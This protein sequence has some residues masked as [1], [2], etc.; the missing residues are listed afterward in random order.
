MLAGLEAAATRHETPCGAGRMVWRV[1]NA[2]GGAP[3]LLLHG[4]SGSWRHWVKQIPWLAAQ[5]M[6]IA[7][8]LPGL[9][10][11]DDPP[12]PQDPATIAGVLVEGLSGIVADTAAMDLVGFSFGAITAGH[13]ARL[14]APRLRSVT[15]CGAGALG[16]PRSPTSLVKVRD[17]QGAERVAAHRHNLAALMFAD[18][19]R[20][21]P[22]ALAIQEI[23]SQAA[24][25]KSRQFAPSANLKDA[26]AAAQG[27]PVNAVW[28]E[29]DAVAWPN[30]QR[31]IETLKEARPDA[32]VAV[33]PGAGHWVAY[34]AAAA[35]DALLRDWITPN[36]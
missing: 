8:D 27:V 16:T 34:E 10:E 24:R 22:L 1:W 19:E 23:N 35:L 4:G 36:R 32:R 12:E 17:K 21:D 30:L 14:L 15:I 25:L 11:S 33:V 20:I 2:P 28:G 3:V 13:V 29:R 26:L 6:V 18:P 9:G 5:R 7:P 31:R